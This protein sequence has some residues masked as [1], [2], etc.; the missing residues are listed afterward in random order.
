MPDG[1]I[2]LRPIFLSIDNLHV[3]YQNLENFYAV[4][5]SKSALVNN[6]VS[7]PLEVS[8]LPAGGIPG[9]TIEVPTPPLLHNSS[10]LSLLG[11]PEC[12]RQSGTEVRQRVLVQEDGAQRRAPWV[13]KWAANVRILRGSQGECL[14]ERDGAR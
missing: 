10:R 13:H 4:W 9:I 6:G 5:A 11:S 2:A 7:L 1:F 12:F 8:G 14:L 3:I